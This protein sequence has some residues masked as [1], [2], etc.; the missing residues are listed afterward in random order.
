MKKDRIFTI[1]FEE[2]EE[3]EVYTQSGIYYNPANNNAGSY[4]GMPVE[5]AD[6]KYI[7]SVLLFI[8]WG[9]ALAYMGCRVLEYTWGVPHPAFAFFTMLVLVSFGSL[10]RYKTEKGFL[11]FLALT[12]AGPA[13]LMMIGIAEGAI[14]QT[15]D[16]CAVKA[17]LIG[18]SAVTAILILVG[19]IRP[20]I[21][22]FTGKT[23]GLTVVA[24]AL[25]DVLLWI[26]YGSAFW[27]I[28]TVLAVLA[29]ALYL[30]YVLT[31]AAV[32]T[33]G[34]EKPVTVAFDAYMRVVTSIQETF[35]ELDEY[36]DDDSLL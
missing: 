34:K 21:Y 32:H 29:I 16:M 22:R 12:M 27:L 1:D 20:T 26:N 18:V 7:T 6:R 31:K 28:W 33:E 11:H 25:A 23:V 36:G 8:L 13:L 5:V 4:F 35:A 3:Y 24:A 9:F 14:K 30:A 2:K 19:L 17:G 15:G 10:I